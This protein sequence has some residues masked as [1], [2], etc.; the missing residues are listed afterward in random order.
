M[1]EQ[2]AYEIEGWGMGEL[3]FANGL[4]AWHELPSS[5]REAAGT[6]ELAERVRRHFAGAPDPFQAPIL[7]SRRKSRAVSRGSGVAP[8]VRSQGYWLSAA[9][10]L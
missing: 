8:C 3:V 10:T 6:H 1:V 5:R 4:V 7:N 2:V 9:I